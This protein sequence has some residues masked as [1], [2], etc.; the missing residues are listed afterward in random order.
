MWCASTNR[1]WAQPGKRQPLSRAFSR[2][3][4]A[5]EIVRVVRPTLSG[6]PWSFSIK[7]ITLESQASRRAVSAAIDGLSSI[8]AAAFAAVSQGV[9][10]TWTMI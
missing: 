6:S 3:R 1:V 7:E 4:S 5:G 9:G 10:S 8:F 2:R